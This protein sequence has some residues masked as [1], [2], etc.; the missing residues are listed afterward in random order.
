MVLCI[1]LYVI[2]EAVIDAP[3]TVCLQDIAYF[4]DRSN[5]FRIRHPGIIITGSELVKNSF[6]KVQSKLVYADSRTRPLTKRR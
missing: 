6:R 2:Y 1:D 4:F 5:S 3:V